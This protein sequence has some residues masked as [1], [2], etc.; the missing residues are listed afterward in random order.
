MVPVVCSGKELAFW[1]YLFH[2]PLPGERDFQQ[3]FSDL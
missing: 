2:H 1:F 3:K